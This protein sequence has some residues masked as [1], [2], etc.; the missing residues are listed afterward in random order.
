MRADLSG[1]TALVTGASSGLGRQ[2]AFTLA[3]RGAAVIVAARR[4]A[5]LED[6]VDQIKA[7]GGSAEARV[8]DVTDVDAVTAAF[9]DLTSLDVVVNNAG[10][11]G[12]SPALECTADEW[13]WTYEINVHGAWFVAQQAAKKMVSNGA[14]GSI[15][16]IASITGERPGGSTAAYASSKAAV[17]HMT[18]ALAM[19]WARYGVRVNALA[20][21]YFTTDLNRDFLASGYGQAMLKRI[22]QRRFGELSDL[23]GPLLLLASDASRYMTGA[24]L[25]VDGGHLCSPL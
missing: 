11:A 9:A 12:A 1:R 15:I 6:L 22:P 4:Q 8:L 20:P 16:N 17:I 13:R 23:D 24:V 7:A 18:K 21:G 10:V 2:F 25:A 5:E 14:G 3:Q 19:E